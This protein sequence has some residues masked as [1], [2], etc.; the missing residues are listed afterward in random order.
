MAKRRDPKAFRLS[1]GSTRAKKFAPTLKQAK[2][3]ARY[4][5]NWGAGRV[6]IERKMPSGSYATVGCTTRRSRR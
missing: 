6:C 2:A 5:T 1:F 3:D 4:W